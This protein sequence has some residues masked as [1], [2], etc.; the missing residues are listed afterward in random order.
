M[1]TRLTQAKVGALTLN[2][3]DGSE[4][5]IPLVVG[6]NVDALSKYFATEL[7]HVRMKYTDYAKIYDIPANGRKKLKSFTIKL[8]AADFEFGLMAANILLALK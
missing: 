1:E 8:D 5:V 3:Y 6:K 7:K 4:S 2:Y